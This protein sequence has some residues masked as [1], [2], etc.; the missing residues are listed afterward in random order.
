MF[1][2]KS[3]RLNLRLNYVVS[4]ASME[5]N[6]EFSADKDEVCIETDENW[7]VFSNHFCGLI[8]FEFRSN[9]TFKTFF[10]CFL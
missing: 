2:M 3:V 4:E 5:R 6:G 9:E 7:A 1:S 10:V 8:Y